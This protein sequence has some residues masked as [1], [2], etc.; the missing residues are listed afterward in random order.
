LCAAALTLCALCILSSPTEDRRGARKAYGAGPP[1]ATP[2]VVKRFYDG[3]AAEGVKEL[4]KHLADRPDDDEARFAL[5]GLQFLR[6][7]ERFGAA[8]HRHGLRTGDAKSFLPHHLQ[9][10]VAENPRPQK[11]TYEGF[12]KIQQGFLDDLATAEATLAKVK[13]PKVKL[14]LQVA[15]IKMDLFGL[16]K[17]VSAAMVLAGVDEKAQKRAEELVIA[18]DR[19]DVC[20]LR[21]YVHFLQ[22]YVE[23]MLALDGKEVFET[24][25]HRF[26]RSIET[27]YGF[28]LEEK[29]DYSKLL[30]P[31]G[32]GEKPS[33]DGDKQKN[34]DKQKDG[35]R[36][37]KGEQPKKEEKPKEAE[38]AESHFPEIADAVAMIVQMAN[39]PVKEPARLKKALEHLE[40]MVAQ[41]KEMWK[42]I[43]AE[44]DDD[45]E[46]IPNPKQKGVLGVKVT[47]EM[48]D[49]WLDTLD[50]VEA[51]LQGKKLIPFWRGEKGA[52]GVNL[53]KAFLEPPKRLDLVRWVQGT[54]AAPYLEKGAVTALADPKKIERLDKVF[55]RNFFGYAA[56]LN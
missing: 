34:A 12:R 50:E 35:D 54:A 10:S 11:I 15:R 55:G 33:K 42:H 3:K 5:G 39:M 48:V 17:P 36:Q 46:W 2:E 40:A 16:G 24:V 7:F 56:W 21:G 51:I 47:K 8:L 28:L 25:G 49:E 13:D 38:R 30:P 29:H 41:A 27:P 19:G 43:L 31:P 6:A 45:R 18:F 1:T 53:R 14:P 22:A 44:E 52:R 37:K 4:A 26:F 20:W 9:E 32:Q 23:V